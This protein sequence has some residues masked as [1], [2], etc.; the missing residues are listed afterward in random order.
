[1]EAVS[2]AFHAVDDRRGLVIGILPASD[3]GPTPPDGYPN[4]WIELS[5]RTHL[6]AR[7]DR[8]LDP[9]S[10]NHVNVLSADVVVALPGG[11]GTAAEIELALR[12]G[13]PVV[14]FAREGDSRPVLA[15]RVLSM[16]AVAAFVEAA[17]A[18]RD[19][20]G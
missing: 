17:L 5:I 2:R 7:G 14:V 9:A 10:R 11:A 8:G 3:E 16:T 12:Y 4:P 19:R 6:P 13:R 15:P 18:G 1:M 20:G